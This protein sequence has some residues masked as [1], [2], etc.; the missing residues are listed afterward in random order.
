MA[1]PT[2][3]SPRGEHETFDGAR[4]GWPPPGTPTACECCGAPINLGGVVIVGPGGQLC[5]VCKLTEAELEALEGPT[6][7]FH[8]RQLRR[9]R[10][11]GIDPQAGR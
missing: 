7:E 8:V 2:S 4:P 10:R 6:A 1:E 9:F 3:R 5:L 11:F